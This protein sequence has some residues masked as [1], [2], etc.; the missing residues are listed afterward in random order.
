MCDLRGVERARAVDEGRPTDRAVELSGLVRDAAWRVL[1]GVLDVDHVRDA[2]SA[3]ELA[4]SRV[5][6]ELGV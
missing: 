4:V 2:A 5:L 6:S 3:A 1:F